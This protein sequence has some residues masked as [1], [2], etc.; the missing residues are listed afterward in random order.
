MM[1]AIDRRGFLKCMAWAGTGLVW[2]V[3]SSGLL[4][5]CSLGSSPAPKVDGFSFVQVS[6]NHVGFSADGVNTDVTKTLQQVV[7]RINALPTRP[8]MVLHTGDVSHLSK[9]AEFDTAR[10]V[11]GDI[12]T[13]RMFFVAGEHDVIEDNG[14][15]F[16][17]RFRQPGQ[18][19]DWFS[20]DVNGVHFAGLW[21]IGDE[22]TFG[23]LG[24][25]QLDWL[26]KDLTAVHHDTP[27]VV[28]AHVPL[29]A[30]YPEWGWAT[31]DGEQAMAFLKPFSS[32]TV[33]N[34]HIHQVA[35]Q[36][37]GNIRFYTA[38]STA[39]PQHL[40]GDG[41]PGAYKLPADELIRK[42]GYR[43]VEVVPGR[44]SLAVVDT[45]LA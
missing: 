19:A 10:Q 18:K 40:P 21:N 11:L 2:T 12:K 32:V 25:E 3:G 17:Q 26:K 36:V 30:L 35:T 7:D 24:Q 33:L 16:R 4:S 44:Q 29:Y 28:F 23:V 13:D 27:L 22:T 6:D 8:A 15:V 14:A 37:E 41:Q 9:P 34:G 5:S 31:K 43:T 42:L 1:D 20:F 45:T 39:F 38:S